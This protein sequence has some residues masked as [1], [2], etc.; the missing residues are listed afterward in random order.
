M[1]VQASFLVL[2]IGLVSAPGV[3]EA[4]KVKT[5]AKAK[6]YS[7]PG[8]QGK[9]VAK[10]KEGQA[11]TVLAKEGRWLKVR[12]SGRTGYVPRSKVDMPDDEEIA[13][14]TRRRPF[15]DGRSTKR[16]FGGDSPDDRIGADATGD[17]ESGNDDDA[18]DKDDDEKPS[19]ASNSKGGR[20]PSKSSTSRGDDNEDDEGGDDEGDDDEPK[21]GDDEEI[22]DDRPKARV[23]AKTT[24]YA[25]PNKGSDKAFTASPNDLLFIESTRGKWT[26]VSVEEGDIG[27]IQTSKLDMDEGGGGSRKRVI[28]VR[29]RLGFTLVSQTLTSPGGGGAWPD[30][31]KVGSSSF[32]VSLGTGVVV[33][34]KKDYL[35][36]GEITYDLA[37][38][39]PG[40]TFDPDGG[41]ATGGPLPSSTTGF[42]IHQ[43]NL[44]GVAG[45]DFHRPSGLAMFGRLGYHY[46]SFQVDNVQDL[47]KNSARLPSEIVRGPMVG[48]ALAVP[49]VTDKIAFKITFDALLFG[50]SVLQTKNLEDGAN[51]TAK[52]INFGAGFVYRFNKS[53]DLNFAY[54]LNYASMTFGAPLMTSQRNHTG[55]GV[56]R[57]DL[58]HTLAGGVIKAF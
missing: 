49:R 17:N 51:P 25:E 41:G 43:L 53:F 38:A 12:V 32:A 37:M 3:S 10:V 9:V 11:M 45:Y 28:D 19:K 22:V 46:N 18:G 6:I 42:K 15:V 44:R 21:G 31:Y 5:N 16:S 40:I 8:E 58:N 29:A 36:G 23:S 52:R 55:T 34:Y 50:A 39:V 7:R 35:L 30:K 57:S 4:E 24:V 33:P 13:R 20:K 47:M 54:D 26:E 48:L 2:L 27:W 56:E 14:N 1:R